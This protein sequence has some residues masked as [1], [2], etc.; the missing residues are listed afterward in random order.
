MLVDW[1]DVALDG[2][3]VEMS[4]RGDTWAGLLHVERLRHDG[5]RSCYHIDGHI[6]LFYGSQELVRRGGRPEDWAERGNC[7]LRRLQKETME[8]QFFNRFGTCMILNLWESTDK[9]GILDMKVDRPAYQMLH[10]LTNVMGKGILRSCHHRRSFH[11]SVR[12]EPDA[13]PGQGNSCAPQ[14]L[15]AMWPEP[16]E[17]K[18]NDQEQACAGQPGSECTSHVEDAAETS[19]VGEEAIPFDLNAMD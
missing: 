8:E 1:T 9:Y 19:S 3:N 7:H 17:P 11:F 6:T 15:V 10:T 2:L 18:S 5:L 4:L 14:P 12:F 13:R 16:S